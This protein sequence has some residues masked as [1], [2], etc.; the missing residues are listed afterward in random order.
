MKNLKGKLRKGLGLLLLIAVFPCTL[1]LIGHLS[2]VA[3]ETST[4]FIVVILLLV[5]SYLI[6]KYSLKLLDF[7]DSP[8]Y[9]LTR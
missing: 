3:L 9:K 1:G 5:V 7:D 2:F 4:L 6:F 8:S